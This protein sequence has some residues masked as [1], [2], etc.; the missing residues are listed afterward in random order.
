MKRAFILAAG[1]GTRLKP[2]TDS[3]PKALVPVGGEPMLSK[4]I[5]RVADAGFDGAVVNVH[6]FADQI[7]DYLASTPQPI[8]IRVSDE[9]AELLETG[10]GLLHAAPLL[11]ADGC[12][13]ILVH[14]VDILSDADLKALFDGHVDS[15]NDVTL[16]VSQRESSRRLWFAPDGRL[17]GWENVKTGEFRPSGYRPSPE[18]RSFAF[19]GI[20]VVNRRAVEQMHLRGYSGRFPIMDF[21]LN[22]LT[23][24]RI[25]A[26]PVEKLTLLDIGKPDALA[27]ANGRQTHDAE[28]SCQG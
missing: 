19:S 3:H 11:F 22:E 20:Y 24:L 2:W 7:T 9:T 15:G 10:G 23:D 4:V 26:H 6:H 5:G 28:A 8:D 17:E 25:S 27:E 12:D 13:D 14:N 16:L 21:F 18:S 1:L